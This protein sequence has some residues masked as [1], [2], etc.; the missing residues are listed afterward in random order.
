MRFVKSR[1]FLAKPL[2]LR[3]RLYSFRGVNANE[4]DALSVTEYERVAVYNPLNTV[5]SLSCVLV[6]SGG[7]QFGVKS[8]DNGDEEQ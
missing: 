3:V 2:H 5:K 7:Y 1:G 4:P 8:K 6:I